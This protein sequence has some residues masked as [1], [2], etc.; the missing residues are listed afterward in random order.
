MGVKGV[1]GEWPQG[2][3]CLSDFPQAKES[4]PRLTFS[5]LKVEDWRPTLCV[6]LVSRA[7]QGMLLRESAQ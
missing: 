5:R 6:Q 4:Q 7:Q 1:I 2:A 3:F